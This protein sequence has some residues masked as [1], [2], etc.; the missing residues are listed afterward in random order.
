[1]NRK[2]IMSHLSAERRFILRKGW[3]KCCGKELTANVDEII[4][5]HNYSA[6]N[7]FFCLTCAK[8][9]GDLANG[10]EEKLEQLGF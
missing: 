5:I 6:G 1:M 2:D 4:S 10:L 9:I 8:T 3:C 7:P